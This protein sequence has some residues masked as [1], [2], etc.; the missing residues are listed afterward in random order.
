M[1]LRLGPLYGR[2]RT[3]LILSSRIRLTQGL[4]I[5]NIRLNGGSVPV[6]RTHR[7][8]KRT[9]VVNNATGAFRSIMR[10]CHTN[11]SCLNVNPF[12]FAAAGGGLDPMLKLRNCSSVLSRVGRTGVRVP[13]MTVKKVACRSVPTVLRAKMGKVTLSKAVLKTSGPMRRAHEVVRDSW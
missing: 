5:S 9:F 11:T 3:V 4:R 7:V 10:R 12:Q 13:M 2:R 6:S 8:L 1:T